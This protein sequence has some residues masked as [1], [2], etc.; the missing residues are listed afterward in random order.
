M[1]ELSRNAPTTGWTG[2]F[3]WPEEVG[4]LFKVRADSVDFMDEIFNTDNA[5]LPQS[6]FND[7]VVRQGDSLFVDLPIAPL[8]DEFTD[9]GQV[10]V[11]ICHVWLNDSEQL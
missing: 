10:G 1:L 5:I 8:V 4:G 11:S 9:G 2:E 7:L 6:I 3:E